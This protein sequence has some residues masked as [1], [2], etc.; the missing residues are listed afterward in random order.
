MKILVS[1]ATGT[2]RRYW[3]NP[4]F[5]FLVTPRS[6]R[7]QEITATGKVWGVDNEAFGGW[8]KQKELSF[9]KLLGRLCEHRPHSELKFVACPD[10]VA[11]CTT[12][13]ERFGRWGP[14]I[15]S[16]GLPVGYVFQDGECDIPWDR[17]DALFIGGSTE[18]KLSQ[19]T[20]EAIAEAKRLGKWVHVGRVNTLRRMRHFH[21]VGVDSFDGTAFSKW[22]DKYFPLAL[23][24]LWKLDREPRLFAEQSQ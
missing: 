4:N 17:I 20:D 15:R 19:Q 6:G 2:H 18:W 12:T 3:D 13:R 11:D 24:W 1:G 10:A 21:E 9:S 14:I 23:R 22:P 8:G 7:V 16:C 5:G